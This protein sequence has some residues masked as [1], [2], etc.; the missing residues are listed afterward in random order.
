MT[1]DLSKSARI[2]TVASWALVRGRS[3]TIRV[4]EIAED[5]RKSPWHAYIIYMSLNLAMIDVGT[6]LVVFCLLI[7]L[8]LSSEAAGLR[9][10]QGRTARGP[11][12][13]SANCVLHFFLSLRNHSIT[14]ATSIGWGPVR[15]TDPARCSHR[16]VN[17]A[18]DTPTSQ[19]W[20][21]PSRPPCRT[22]CLQCRSHRYLEF[23]LHAFYQASLGMISCLSRREMC[24][25]TRSGFKGNGATLHPTRLSIDAR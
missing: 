21:R 11:R 24:R 6:L 2:L 5:C 12:S 17:S 14:G 23:A 19:P 13:S 25:L 16:L 1:D 4:L 20:R 8:P 10:R 22:P 18:S 7:L 3:M 15:V 9:R